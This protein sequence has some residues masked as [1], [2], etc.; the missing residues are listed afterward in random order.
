[1]EDG[2]QESVDYNADG[3]SVSYPGVRHA[4]RQRAL[5]RV[6]NNVHGLHHNRARQ[7]LLH[8]TGA[9]PNSEHSFTPTTR[10]QPNSASRW[11]AKTLAPTLF[12]GHRTDLLLK[13]GP[14]FQIAR[15]RTIQQTTTPNI[16]SAIMLF[17]T[18]LLLGEGKALTVI[19][20]LGAPVW[21]SWPM[22][23]LRLDRYRTPVVAGG[24]RGCYESGA[25]HSQV[26][27]VLPP[28]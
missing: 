10:R 26:S 18:E 15:A 8:V 2:W 1:M 7:P 11:S 4:G 13:P 21:R 19:R 14:H 6:M 3:D 23:L 9:F 22:P 20:R 17:M 28:W 5:G 24:W 25:E 27:V 12:S 16:S